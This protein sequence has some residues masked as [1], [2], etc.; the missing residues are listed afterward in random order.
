MLPLNVSM[1]F[2]AF[3]IILLSPFSL[4]LLISLLST[5]KQCQHWWRKHQLLHMTRSRAYNMAE[6]CTRTHTA[7]QLRLC[8]S[9]T[10][11]SLVS[12][13]WRHWNPI[14]F[15]EVPLESSWTTHSRVDCYLKTK[16]GKPR[17]G[18]I[19]ILISLRQQNRT[20]HSPWPETVSELY[21]PKDRRLPAKLVPTSAYR[22][23]SGIQC[24]WSPTVV[25][26]VF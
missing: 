26:S 9:I 15:T 5:R 22:G 20:K 19:S 6:G 13:S 8:N 11:L 1:L 17:S 12:D 16:L 14:F 24:G 25:I 4:S 2:S 7:I 18:Q 10:D 3:L 21:R 23:V